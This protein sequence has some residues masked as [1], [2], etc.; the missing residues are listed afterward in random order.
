MDSERRRYVVFWAFQDFRSEDRQMTEGEARNLFFGDPLV[1]TIYDEQAGR[2]L[3]QR[4]AFDRARVEAAYGAIPANVD[5]MNPWE[6]R[7]V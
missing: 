4:E 3:L 7:D 5:A 1:Q 6:A 2:V